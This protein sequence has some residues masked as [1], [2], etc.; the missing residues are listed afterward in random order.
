LHYAGILERQQAV[1]LGGFTNYKST[2]YDNGYDFDAMLQF[3]RSHVN[4][5]IL[6]GLPFGHFVKKVTLPIGAQAEL[7]STAA[8]FS[9]RFS[10]YAVLGVLSR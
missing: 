9:L 8:G 7:T 2:E 3:I 4:V 1:I 10:D 5:P 6:K